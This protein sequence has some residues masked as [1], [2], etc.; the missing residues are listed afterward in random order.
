MVAKK[1][2]PQM[3]LFE[4]TR[5]CKIGRQMARIGWRPGEFIY[6]NEA[7]LEL[8]YVNKA[9]E[10]AC[11]FCNDDFREHAHA[12]DYIDV[13]GLTTVTPAVRPSLLEG[14]RNTP[15]DHTVVYRDCAPNTVATPPF[16][17]VVRIVA[18]DAFA[19][20]QLGTPARVAPSLTRYAGD[21][22]WKV[23]RLGETRASGFDTEREANEWIE[24]NA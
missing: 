10:H 5:R 16:K 8:W 11:P 22:T 2:A 24:N 23:V 17:P 18:D 13:T 9:D 12:T 15:P 19:P 1:V 20:A 21:G 3:N 7:H 6:W 4:A 14:F